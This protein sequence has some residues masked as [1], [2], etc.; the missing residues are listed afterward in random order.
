MRIEG[1]VA[2]VTGA[3]RGIGRATAIALASRG[4]KLLLAC[5]DEP[6]IEQ[7]VADTGGVLHRVDVSIAGHADDIVQA[8]RDQF[9][10][11]DLVVA[12]AGIGHAGDFVDMSADQI[13]ALIDINV[14][15]P[16]QLAKA[17]VPDMVKQGEGAVVF[18]TSI[19]G[20]LPLP[21]EAVYSMTKA[22]IETFAEALREEVRGW[23][24]QVSTIAPAVVATQF[25]E[26]RGAPYTRKFPRPM[27]P[28]RVAAAVTTAIERNRE[29]TIVPPWLNVPVRL[30]RT[31]PGAYRA[32][33][34]RFS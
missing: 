3:G 15:A 1:K 20:L 13:D 4:A 9:G 14:T 27:P 12:N 30:Q 21:T 8:A 25:F 2:V 23:G 18:I 26:R 34:R 32:L 17:A 5:H 11:L 29:R 19:A 7:V 16:V 33:A 28:E 22:S 31:M 10:R 6:D 24:V